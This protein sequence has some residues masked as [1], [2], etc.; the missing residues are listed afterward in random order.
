MADFKEQRIC[1]KFC[2]KLKKTAAE[3]HQMLK[4][5]FGDNA[6]SQSKLFCGTNAS[7]T[8]ERLSM[9]M[10]V[11]DDHRQAQHRKTSQKCARLSLQIVGEL[12]MMFVRS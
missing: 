5:A 2:F 1:I 6:M 7:R 10:S 12:S 8:D 3:S 11:L 9:T 4:E